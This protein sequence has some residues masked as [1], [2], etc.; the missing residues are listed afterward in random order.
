[1]AVSPDGKFVVSSGFETALY[2]WDPQ[3][4]QRVR[5]QGGH[6]VA[7]HEICFSKD[8][9]LVAS[10]GADKT[11]RLWNG[12]TGA[13]IR[14]LSVGSSTYATALS[15]NGKLV[16]SGSFD[17]FV[18]LWDVA[19]GR[20]LLTLLSLPGQGEKFDW[21][22][23]TPEGYAASSAGLAGLGQWR[24]ANQVV[25]AESVWKVLGKPEVVARA[26]RG[27]TLPA[28]SFGK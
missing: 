15:P 24:M 2:W 5:T 26:V 14:A 1:M 4:G 18:R 16:A 25:A 3:T 10:A 11:V 12:A 17:G 21:L 6:G 19:T 13:M 23:L 9:Q 8:G 20:Q 27:E 7:V 22:A 28:L